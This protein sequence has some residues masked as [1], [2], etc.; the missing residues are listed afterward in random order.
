MRSFFVFDVESV[1]LHGEGFAVGGGVYLENGAA[2][3][4]FRFACPIDSAKGDDEG[5]EWVKKNTPVLE[6]THHN[7][8]GIR[9][10]FWSEWIKAKT[11]Y[12]GVVMAADCGWPVEARFVCACINDDPVSRRWNGPYPLLEISSVIMAVGKVP[13]A[14]YPRTES[15]KP[16]HDPMADARQSARLLAEALKSCS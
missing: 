1:D 4:E 8:L 13:L 5:R 11:A 16:E 12:P 6:V 14:K 2:Q 9:D 3:Y 10:A 15:E 7:P